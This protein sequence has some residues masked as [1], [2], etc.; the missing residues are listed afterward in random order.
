M[1]NPLI[2][3]LFARLS[4]VSK[5]SWILSQIKKKTVFV[6]TFTVLKIRVLLKKYRHPDYLIFDF[7]MSNNQ[8]SVNSFS[9]IFSSKKFKL[10]ILLKKKGK[11][12]RDYISKDLVS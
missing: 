4:I 11:I 10:E 12:I 5:S 2:F 9:V 1:T 3:C 8:S 7:S 6:F